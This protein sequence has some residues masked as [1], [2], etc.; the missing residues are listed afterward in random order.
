MTGIRIGVPAASLIAVL[1]AGLAAARPVGV[2]AGDATPGVAETDDP[3]D[4][5]LRFTM[6]GVFLRT[7]DAAFAAPEIL[8]FGRRRAG[9]TLDGV[10]VSSFFARTFDEAYLP[11]LVTAPLRLLLRVGPDP[12]ALEG[13]TL[14]GTITLDPP[15]PPRSPYRPYTA[16][17]RGAAGF[18]GDS[19][20]PAGHVWA[21]LA[22]GDLDASLGLGGALLGAVAG[23]STA[24]ERVGE[25]MA[26][27]ATL[28]LDGPIGP[29]D[30]IRVLLRLD[31]ADG[32]VRGPESLSSG[33]LRVDDVRNHVVVA[34]YAHGSPERIRAWAL[35]RSAER[36]LSAF[37]PEWNRW[38]RSDEGLWGLAGGARVALGEH[39]WLLDLS[40]EFRTEGVWAASSRGFVAGPGSHDDLFGQW[41]LRTA[42]DGANRSGAAFALT[43]G[44]HDTKEFADA[45][46]EIWAVRVT[47]ALGAHRLYLPEDPYGQ[48]A[49]EAYAVTERWEAE[50]TGTIEGFWRL[51]DGLEL[52]GAIETGARPPAIEEIV[53]AGTDPAADVRWSPNYELEPER[54]WGGRLGARV[55]FGIVAL[56]FAYHAAW[57]SD[58]VVAAGLGAPDA[59]GY[60]PA[61]YLNTGQFVQGGA[62]AGTFFLHRDLRLRIIVE[63]SHGWA[64]D[65]AGREFRPVEVAPISVLG[66]LAYI[67]SGGD[68]AAGFYGGYR[69]RPDSW[70]A[71]PVEDRLA[72]ACV[73]GSVRCERNRDVPLG[74]FVK[75]WIAEFVGLELRASDLAVQGDGPAVQGFVVGRY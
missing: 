1:A 22:I 74:L 43:A 30:T 16:S 34:S 20:G 28:D 59:G 52:R 27:N 51:A 41:P 24:P 39:H 42:L 45:V 70:E 46:E 48:E 4:P 44:I 47:A 21:G 12:A 14:A 7:L 32:L 58:A 18:A 55:D 2:A 53:P 50:P 40:A 49:P 33:F 36:S 26:A 25:A 60:L 68:M 73:L 15:S 56:D 35:V 66:E 29:E 8:G 75:W 11:A 10:R 9:F 17:A 38:S 61:T 65:G 6:P 31:A 69:W 19:G 13:D 63:S 62:V 67:P 72:G 54:S 57:I 3:F 5:R 23:L 37:D 64:D 71:S